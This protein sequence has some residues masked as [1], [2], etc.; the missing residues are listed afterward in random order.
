MEAARPDAPGCPRP[1]PEAPERNLARCRR[2]LEFGE[3]EHERRPLRQRQAAP[4]G[5]LEHLV[6][7][8]APEGY[9]D[10]R[11]QLLTRARGCASRATHDERHRTS[12]DERGLPLGSAEVAA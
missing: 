9:C 10:H 6:A 11:P 7:E 12:V 2:A 5:V 3:I 8:P 1:D 4:G